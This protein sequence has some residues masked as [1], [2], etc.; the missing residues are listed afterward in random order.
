MTYN[1]VGE[2]VVFLKFNTVGK[3][4][5][6][7]LETDVVTLK[8]VVLWWISWNSTG[9]LKSSREMNSCCH[10][11]FLG[12]HELISWMMCKMF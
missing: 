5:G 11:D 8:S 9:V 12:H 1:D 7:A 10:G 2:D 4:E 3:D 6:Y